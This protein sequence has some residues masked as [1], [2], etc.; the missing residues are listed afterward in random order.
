MAGVLRAISNP[1]AEAFPQ[2]LHNVAHMFLGSDAE[3]GDSTQVID[4]DLLVAQIM[5][6]HNPRL[7]DDE[8]ESLL[9]QEPIVPPQ[10][11]QRSCLS[12]H[13]QPRGMPGNQRGVNMMGGPMTT[14][15]K[16][17]LLM[18]TSSYGIFLG[19]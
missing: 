4:N 13:H 5:A 9:Q 18:Q 15:T 16:K 8:V 10:N 2:A 17:M 7:P 14:C 6:E 1:F 3:T 19:L 11:V 12:Q